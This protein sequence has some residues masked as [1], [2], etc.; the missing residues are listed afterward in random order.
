MNII[1][2]NLDELNSTIKIQIDPEDYHDKVEEV[3]RGYRKKTKF[4]GFRPGKVPY[5]MVKKMYGT[6]ALLDQ[7]NHLLSENLNKYLTDNKLRILGEPLPNENS[8]SI[9][10]DTQTSFE[11][12]FDIA[13]AP[14]VVLNLSKKDKIDQYVIEADDKIIEEQIN[15]F[16]Q[17]FGSYVAV[18]KAEENDLIKGDFIQLD[19]LGEPLA[20]GLRAEDA[21]VSVSTIADEE[22]K[23]Q[24]I[25]IQANEDLVFDPFLAF[26]ND[27]DLAA[28]LKIKKDQLGNIHGQFKYS[29]SEV[30]RFQPATIDQDLFDKTFGEGTITSLDDYRERIKKDIEVQFGYETSYK[31]HMDMREKLVN[32]ADFELP[33]EFL[34][35]WML[36]TTKDEKLTMEKIEEEY[37]S[38]KKDLRWQLIKE[39]FIE[40]QSIQAEPEEIKASAVQ[41]ARNRFQ[42]Y[43]MYDVPE[44]QLESLAESILSKKDEERKIIEHIQENKVITFVKELVKVEDKNVSLDEFKK[45][46]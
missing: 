37:P 19:K 24:F 7:V 41:D 25:G 1:K 11:F 18:E 34:K 8:P 16:C 9:D 32:K 27:A 4:D 31:F 42:Q 6:T 33:D 28:M 45:L 2:E 40:E 30:S 35:R 29:I 14:E 12:A 39:K 15:N 44:E 5:G 36:A 22:I 26:P 10:W 43:G 21:R 20:N 13:L 38:F 17:R 3:L 23:K 46:F